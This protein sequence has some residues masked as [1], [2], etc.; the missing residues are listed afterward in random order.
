MSIEIIA[1]LA[2]GFE[3]SPEQARLM[4]KAAATAGADAA[5]YQLVYADELATPDY[6]YYSLFLSLEMPDEVWQGLGD[7][8]RELG[9]RLQLDIFGSRSL[10]LANRIGVTEIKLHGTDIANLG[11]LRQLAAGPVRKVLLGAGGAHAS[12]I[13][14]AVEIL[15]D[16]QVVVLLGY[17]GYPTPVEG[18]QIER[19][20]L[21]VE[22]FKAQPNVTIGFADHAAPDSTLRYSLAAM[23]VGAGAKVLEK[24][25]TL[26][27]IMKIEDHEAALNPD[28]FLEFSQTI[29]GCETALGEASDTEDFGMSE[30]EKGYRT[31]I[32]RHVVAARDLKAGAVIVPEDV[33][34]KRTA[35]AEPVTDLNVAY[36][37]TLKRDVPQ[38]CPV[39]T[40]SL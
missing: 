2:Q 37:R 18:N 32:R 27:R 14:Q 23:A 25:L 26:G 4:M 21:A 20:R 11:L 6:K 38:N 19:V 31:M 7:Y 33:I 29:R 30:S 15:A 34:L 28:E 40:D 24:H 5:K 22:R 17:Q 10:E 1:E 16:K 12:E 35:A 13:R 3:G 8:A 36:D 9:I 39:T